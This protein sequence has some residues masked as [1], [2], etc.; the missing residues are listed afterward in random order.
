MLTSAINAAR[1][2]VTVG[3]RRPLS[4][5]K[6]ERCYY[7]P[8]EK[9]DTQARGLFSKAFGQALRLLRERGCPI[10]PQDGMK[11]EVQ[12]TIRTD[13]APEESQPNRHSERF[14]LLCRYGFNTLVNG[15]TKGHGFS[16]FKLSDLTHP[17]PLTEDALK[18]YPF[19]SIAH[20][21]RTEGQLDTYALPHAI[22]DSIKNNI[23]LIRLSE[24]REKTKKK[25]G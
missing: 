14:P 20:A 7:P 21:M 23:D 10:G 11:I 15:E 1:F 13:I 3:M 8:H 24:D 17:I 6:D 25:A 19:S 12:P 5:Q 2:G 16:R 22:A 9:E 4:M 18:S